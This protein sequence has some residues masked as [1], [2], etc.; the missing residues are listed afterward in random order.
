MNNAVRNLL[1]IAALLFAVTYGCFTLGVNYDTKYKLYP[2]F[3]TCS[4]CCVIELGKYVYGKRWERLGLA[5]GLAGTAVLTLTGY[6]AVETRRSVKII[7][8][9]SE[10]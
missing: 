6:F 10:N 8:I 7:S 3:E 9:L 4:N 2:E 1:F 5:T